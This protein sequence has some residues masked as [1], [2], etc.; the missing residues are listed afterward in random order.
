MQP[1]VADPYAVLGVPRGASRRQ[2]ADAY[3]RLAKRH[4]PDVNPDPAAVER[5]RRI[6][7][8]W[9][10][11]SSPTRRADHDAS[12]ASSGHW[13]SSRTTWRS[14]S[15]STASWAA[16]RQRRSDRDPSPAWRTAGP[17]PI[18]RRRY[19]RPE[20]EDVPFGDTGWATLLV[21]SVMLLVLF[22]AAYAGSLTA[23]T[24]TG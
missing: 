2:V 19:R 4:H 17:S 12:T 6:N 3:R 22:A 11:L 20:P 1:H 24:A 23:S 18:P 14:E 21:A 8:A 15:A 7:A 13:T 10:T 16:W 5:M 9:Q